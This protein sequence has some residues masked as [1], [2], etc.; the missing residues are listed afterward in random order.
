MLLSTAKLNKQE[1]LG[2]KNASPTRANPEMKGGGWL[3]PWWLK[4]EGESLEREI[5]CGKYASTVRRNFMG[6]KEI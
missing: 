6:M 5:I 4:R 2:G 3:H 1:T